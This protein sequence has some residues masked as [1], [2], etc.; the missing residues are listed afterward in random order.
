MTTAASA[1]GRRIDLE[2]L[3]RL[4]S[5]YLPTVAWAGDRVAFYWDR[6]G[7]L[8]LYVLDLRTRAVRQVSHGE[9]PRAVRTGFVW[10]RADRALVFGKDELGNEQHDLYRID[11]ATGEVTPL[12]HDPTAEEHAVEFSPDNAW[13]TTNT[14]K[15]RPDAPDQPAQM[16]VWRMRAD[17]SD[18]HPL[19]RYAFPA[20]GG[21]WS[22]DGRWLSF[23]T[24]EDPSNLKNRDG[25]LMRPDGSEVRK[26][27]SLTPGSQ[28]LLVDWHPDSRHI[29]VQSDASGLGRVGVLA[30]ETGEVRWLTPEGLNEGGPVRFSRSGRHLVC[31]RNHEAQ[32]RPIIYDVASGQAR[33]LHLPAGVATAAEFALDDA[34]VLVAYSTSTA[35]PSL[36][37]Y[38]LGRDTPE[39]LLEPEYGSIDPSVF[40][41]AQHVWY[42]SF[43][44]LQI[45]ALLYVPSDAAE[46][47]RLPALVHVHGGPTEQWLRRFDPLVQYLVSRGLVVLAPNIRGSTGYGVEFRDAALRDWGGAD[48]QDVA[49]GAEYLKRLPSVDPERLGVFG[50][51]YG[52]YMTFMAVT[53]QP[54]LWK[55]AAASVGISD[56]HRLYGRSMEH[57]RYF[58]R[59]QM[60]DPEQEAALWRDRSAINFAEHLRAKLLI[61]HGAND[62]R[63]PVE[64]ARIFRDRLRALG[65]REGE[66]FE[67]V[68]YGDIGHDSVDIEHKLRNFRLMADFFERVL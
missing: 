61:V 24:N 47:K 66:D 43:D 57:F 29:A 33:D 49:A 54:D 42:P 22:P 9:V 21:R 63:C 46:D 44:G 62:P 39:M 20:Y 51:S 58:L 23:G 31:L 60:G 2:A 64:Q 1:R 37:L 7:R 30:I 4:P 45:P 5:F 55:A 27:F 38:D 48:L 36:A 67:Y 68:E 40:V 56:L 34:H 8:E 59:T 13:L 17:G 12:G 35:R 6:T 50:G 18:Y 26:V 10:D 15:R 41:E 14:N 19:T 53:R 25:Y 16:N 52:G 28:D 3:A 65:K 11:L 32:V